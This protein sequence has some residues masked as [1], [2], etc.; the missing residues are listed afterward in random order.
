MVEQEETIAISDLRSGIEAK[1]E[2]SKEI[3]IEEISGGVVKLRVQQPVCLQSGRRRFIEVHQTL[4][5]GV[6][7]QLLGGS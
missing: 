1:E 4:V 5:G 2:A 6:R 7:G 3:T